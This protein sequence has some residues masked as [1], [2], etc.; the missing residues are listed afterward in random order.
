M[1]EWTAVEQLPLLVEATLVDAD[2]TRWPPLVVNL[3]LAGTATGTGIV[4]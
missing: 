2:G 3:Q 4:Q 1:D